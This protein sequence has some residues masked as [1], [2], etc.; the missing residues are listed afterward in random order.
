MIYTI[1]RNFRHSTTFKLEDLV[2]VNLEDGILRLE[3][4]FSRDPTQQLRT[5][6][7]QLPQDMDLT[8]IDFLH[9]DI[10]NHWVKYLEKRSV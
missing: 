7:V 6:T 8:D 5:I 3:L 1:H 10:L 4:I 2:R 9:T